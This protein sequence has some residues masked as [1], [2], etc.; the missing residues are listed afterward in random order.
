MPIMSLEQKEDEKH[1]DEYP[2]HILTEAVEGV[3]G[4]ADLAAV[5]P[6]RRREKGYLQSRM[7]AVHSL[8]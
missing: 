3:R 2:P 8:L 7:V 1:H 6:H 4:K 5:D